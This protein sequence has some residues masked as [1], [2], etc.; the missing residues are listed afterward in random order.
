MTRPGV[1]GRAL[2]V[3]PLEGGDVLVTHVLGAPVR[4]S[5]EMWRLA[6]DPDAPWLDERTRAASLELLAAKRVRWQSEQAE[7]AAIAERFEVEPGVSLMLTPLL[8]NRWRTTYRAHDLT[9][10]RLD[11]GRAELALVGSCQLLA[12]ADPLEYM[13]AQQ[14]WQLDV[15]GFML[16]AD[17]DDRPWSL[18][19]VSPTLLAARLFESAAADDYKGMRRAAV[20]LVARMDRVLARIRAQTSAPIAFVRLGSPGLWG[21]DTRT[22]LELCSVLAEVNEQLVGGLQRTGSTRV[23][24]EDTLA[25]EVGFRGVYWDDEFNAIPHH[26][27][28]SSWTFVDFPADPDEVGLTRDDLRA[29]EPSRT[30]DQMDPAAGLA[31]AVWR[32]LLEVLTPQRIE[33]IV[34]EPNDLLWPGRLEDRDRPYPGG[35]PHFYTADNYYLYAGIHEAL[36]TLARRGVKL[37]CRS[38]CPADVL[39]QRWSYQSGL[40]NLV[41]LADV[42][43]LVQAQHGLADIAGALGVPESRMLVVDP[44]SPRPPG[45]TAQWY[46]GD[47]WQLRRWLLTSPQLGPRPSEDRP[48]A[49]CRAPARPPTR[50]LEEAAPA[51]PPDEVALGVLDILRERFGCDAATL[52][53]TDDLRL[54]GLDSFGGMELMLS[55]QDQ[56]GVLFDD[57]DFVATTVFSVSGLVQASIRAAHR[58]GPPP[59]EQETGPFGG[60]DFR[61]WCSGDVAQM[62]ADHARRPSVPWIFK[63]L[64]SASRHDAEYVTWR[65]LVERASGYARRYRDLGVDDS[66]VVLLVLPQGVE[67]IAAFV[68]AILAGVVPSICAHPSHKHSRES[69]AEWFGP[70]AARSGAQLVV[71]DPEWADLLRT[72]LGRY[73][74]KTPVETEVPPPSSD[75]P[76]LPPRSP[77][78]PLLLQHSSGTTGLKKAVRLGHREVLSQVWELGHALDCDEDDRIV[79]WLPLYHDMGLVACLL[80]PL[81]CSIPTVMMSPFDWVDQPWLLPEQASD[82]R[83]TLCWLPNFAYRHLS[84]RIPPPDSCSWDLTRLRAVIDCSEP[85]TAASLDALYDALA[86]HGLRYS[87]LS[88]SY[89]MAEATFAVTQTPAGHPPT[90]LL[91]EREALQRDGIAREVSA[92]NPEQV[93][94]LELV[95]S[96]RPLPRSTVTII[97]PRGDVLP[98][99]HIGEI[100]VQSDSLMSGYY[101]PDSVEAPAVRHGCFDTGDL[102]FRWRGEL[103]VTGR[104]KDLVIVGGHNVYPHE[105]EE[106]VSSLAFVRAGRVVAFGVFDEE[107]QT[108]RLVVLMEAS[109]QTDGSGSTTAYAEQ[110]R[111]LVLGTFGVSVHEV[112]FVPSRSLV[113]S[114]SGKTSRSRNRAHYLRSVG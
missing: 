65:Q 14:G 63:V 66:E 95:S 114:T 59:A 90:R 110:V 111:R 29:L 19:V 30:P 76:A 73:G 105:V 61:T 99:G 48:P 53:E 68:G 37:V 62:L 81:L 40:R 24:D 13:A 107:L 46:E 67:L 43:V 84:R 100:R 102:G 69:F 74:L 64:R 70:V 44:G 20:E 7:Q 97:G 86:V 83:A 18:V 72:E 39:R 22:R 15:H 75:L 54:L 50:M 88:S 12:A 77:D 101:D 17:I 5:P 51:T 109:V 8:A 56:L 93:P 10:T 9:T 103:F 96:G 55:I 11:R 113:K 112:R 78:R 32:P 80:L 82:E 57:A 58:D 16:G 21:A 3:F 35:G 60:L 98:D 92:R 23:I 27:P 31:A 1:V 6:Q 94:S 45:T 71:A 34:I 52:D 91:V 42:Q 41:R 108:E 28:V 85:I 36:V 49:E 4:L 79:S 106:L 87:A 89:A 38:T 47:R 33:A 104:S 2:T 26:S 25:S